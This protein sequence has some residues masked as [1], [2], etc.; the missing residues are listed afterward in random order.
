MHDFTS[1]PLYIVQ[2]GSWK[3]FA[4]TRYPQACSTVGACLSFISCDSQPIYSIHSKPTYHLAY[5]SSSVWAPSVPSLSPFDIDSFMNPSNGKLRKPPPKPQT[6]HSESYLPSL[7]WIF[8]SNIPRRRTSNL[9]PDINKR[10]FFG[11]GEI[12]TVLTNV[13]LNFTMPFGPT[14]NYF[15]LI[16][17]SLQKPPAPSRSLRNFSTR[18]VKK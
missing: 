14:T 16:L 17:P 3:A 11:M 15:E 18:H 1:R 8:R 7:H 13:K 6:Q 5:P 4:N 2:Q 12:I 9:S 10:N